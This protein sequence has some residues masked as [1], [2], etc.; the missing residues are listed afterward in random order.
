MG[1]IW[2]TSGWCSVVVVCVCGVRARR[3]FAVAISA[4][5]A[6]AFFFFHVFFFMLHGIKIS[7]VQWTFFF[8]F[9]KKNEFFLKK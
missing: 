7:L 3:I 1:D 8:F 4:V 2:R 9:F 5:C 6:Q